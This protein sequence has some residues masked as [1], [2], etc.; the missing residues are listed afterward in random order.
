[1]FAIRTYNKISDQGLNLFSPTSYKLDSKLEE[2]NPDA[3]VLRSQ[4]LHDEPIP[5]STVAIARAGAGTNNV[6]IKQ[7]SDRGVVVFNTPGANANAVKE[8]VLSG[9]LIASRNIIEGVN[10][11]RDLESESLSKS[12]LSKHLEAS[13]KQFSGSELIGKTLGVVGLGA[14]GSMVANMAEDLGMKVLGYDPAISI[15]AAWQLSR[16]VVKMDSIDTLLRNSDFVS[17]HVPAIE[18]TKHLINAKSCKLFKPNAVLLNFAREEIVDSEA[19]CDALNNN[20]FAR[21]VSDFPN[22][23]MLS[24]NSVIP[25]P[26]IGASTEEAETNCAIM[27]V[28]QVKDYLENGNIKNSVNFPTAQLRREG[29]CRI[30]FCNRN[31]PNMLSQTLE[32]LKGNNVIHMLNRSRGD[33]AY[34]LLDLEQTPTTEM[35]DAIKAIDGVMNLRLLC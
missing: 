19:V 1:M 35:I 11:V 2:Q 21:Y 15:E 24:M 17:L 26:H 22:Q 31:Q 6:P 7:L 18:A 5:E 28:N 3:I 33:Y 14:I 10:F 29:A 12:E 20:Q 9:M 13:K 34:S 27:A 32:C 30:A 4:V 23:Q 25:M 8:L 16:N